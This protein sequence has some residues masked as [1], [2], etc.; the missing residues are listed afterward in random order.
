MY[1]PILILSGIILFSGLTA[2]KPSQETKQD[3]NHNT[4]QKISRKT[5]KK[6]TD[7]LDI[8]QL[9]H[10]IKTLSSDAFEGRAPAT[11]GG[12]KT[13]QWIVD[14]YKAINLKPANKGSYFQK[15]PLTENTLNENTSYLKISHNG[16]SQN[17][18]IGQDAVF[19]TK[20]TKEK[21]AFKNSDL[22]FVGY[23]IIAPEYGWNDYKDIDVKG[24]TVIILVNDPGYA[25]QNPDLFTGNAMTY[26]GR[27][28][29]K[30]E[31]AARQGA[32]A[33]LI[34][35]ETKPASYPWGVVNSGWRGAQYDLVKTALSPKQ[36]ALEGWIQLDIAKTL[37][38]QA[39][40][41]YQTLKKQAKQKDFKAVPMTGLKAESLLNNNLKYLDSAN[42][43]GMI[44]GTKHPDEYV[45]F[46]AHWDH[47]GKENVKEG[48][49]GIYN[50]AVDNAT[51][52]ASILEIAKAFSKYSPAP[53]RSLLF[54]AVTAE[55]SGLLGSKYFAEHPL[56]P[57]KDIVAGINIDAMLPLGKT[58]NLS[59]IGYGAS[60]VED[61]LKD[62][63]QKYHKILS[64]DPKPE[65]GSFYRS[66]HIN[67]AKKGVPMIYVDNG[68]DHIE[69]GISYGNAFSSDYVKNRYHKPTD[70]YSEDWDLT[71]MIEDL[72]ILTNVAKT[73]AY[74]NQ[75]P[76]WYK[77]NEFKAI[78]DQSR[79]NIPAH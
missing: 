33:A 30:Y 76:N 52:V 75:W 8:K 41:E 70:E 18:K 39:G 51:G 47:L 78:R 73:L 53:E 54:L 27:W 58:R 68:D 42:V 66:D 28:T 49:D 11:P 35:H 32:I 55:E 59:V 57:L 14:Q 10:H 65:A 67:L 63:A 56:V 21:I 48:E 5:Q 9:A 40:L 45:L 3:N 61:I 37:F 79:K 77:G 71:G 44:T 15:V 13:R 22:V 6:L 34:V 69:K 64:P 43:A 38:K 36:L 26:Y 23:G 20:Q 19:G 60:E 2:C 24:K 50:G 16:T 72:S 17:L 29:Y 74:S 31:E 4:A 12:K 7:Y 25:T 46:M 62:E 1:K